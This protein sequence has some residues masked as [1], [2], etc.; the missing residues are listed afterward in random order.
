MIRIQK[1]ARHA[2]HG[3][4]VTRWY[5]HRYPWLTVV[6]TMRIRITPRRRLRKQ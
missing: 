3:R 1:V 6:E 4:F 2:G 5:A